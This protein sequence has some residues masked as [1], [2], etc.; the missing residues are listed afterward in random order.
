MHSLSLNKPK[1]SLTLSSSLKSP[2]IK[3]IELSTIDNSRPPSL[4]WLPLLTS[5]GLSL[6]ISSSFVI[7][8]RGIFRPSTNSLLFSSPLAPMISRQHSFLNC[9]LWSLN[10]RSRPSY[11]KQQPTIPCFKTA[12]SCSSDR[13]PSSTLRRPLP[14]STWPLSLE[15]SLGSSY[16][17]PSRTYLLMFCR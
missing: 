16:P 1:P 4:Q 14:Q 5:L 8:D 6:R 13:L 10:S 15:D 3:L 11:A 7:R 12:W 17:P 9:Y 2:K